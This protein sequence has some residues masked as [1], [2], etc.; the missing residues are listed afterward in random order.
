MVLL[1]K[2]LVVVSCLTFGLLETFVSLNIILDFGF[3]VLAVEVVKV[4]L[5]PSG[6]VGGVSMLLFTLLVSSSLHTILYVQKTSCNYYY[7]I[8]I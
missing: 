5:K 6:V 8:A 1:D 2:C 7:I 4:S 3:T